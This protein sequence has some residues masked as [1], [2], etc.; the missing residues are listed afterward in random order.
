MYEYEI[1]S[2]P[3]VPASVRQSWLTV[4]VKFSILAGFCFFTMLAGAGVLG[5][6]VLTLDEEIP[7]YFY[8]ETAPVIE[9]LGQERT[10]I[11]DGYGPGRELVTTRLVVAPDGP[12]GHPLTLKQTVHRDYL[13]EDLLNAKGKTLIYVENPAFQEKFVLINP[14]VEPVEENFDMRDFRQVKS[15]PFLLV[16]TIL[17]GALT[18]LLLYG[19]NRYR[20]NG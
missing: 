13:E 3:S 15:M 4:S 5:F 16:A 19:A 6:F 10:P 11:H 20:A 9:I 12:P 2:K 7:F 1:D 8:A 17:F 14:K 18:A